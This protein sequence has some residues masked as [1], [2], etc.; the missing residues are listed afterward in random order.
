MRTLMVTV[1][2]VIAGLIA[3]LAAAWLTPDAQRWA[4]WPAVLINLGTTLLVLIPVYTIERQLNRRIEAIRGEFDAAIRDLL[5]ELKGNL[6]S[7]TRDT[8][9][10]EV[11][12]AEARFKKDQNVGA[13]LDLLKIG[14]KYSLYA[15]DAIVISL[16]AAR[17][18]WLGI[19]AASDDELVEVYEKKGKPLPASGSVLKLRI[20]S[21]D[22]IP[23]AKTNCFFTTGYDLPSIVTT[24]VTQPLLAVS[25]NLDAAKV[26]SD[27]SEGLGLG[28]L[29]ALKQRVRMIPDPRQRLKEPGLLISMV[30]LGWMIT[31]LGIVRN[32]DGLRLHARS[33]WLGRLWW[34]SWGLDPEESRGYTKALRLARAMGRVHPR[35]EGWWRSRLCTLGNLGFVLAWAVAS[36]L[37]TWLCSLFLH[38]SSPADWALA[39]SCVSAIAAAS[40]ILAF[41]KIGEWEGDG[42]VVPGSLLCASIMSWVIIWTAA[43]LESLMGLNSWQPFWLC[44]ALVVT[45]LS[46]LGAASFI[47]DGIRWW[48]RTRIRPPFYVA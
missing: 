20:G 7:A 17:P 36:A 47:R 34:G 28:L 41:V 45:V 18:T 2:L 19:A 42:W 8:M 4:T 39:A 31:D 38:F 22:A 27:V 25:G 46:L 11:N 40:L 48:R 30:S 43:P 23:Q 35:L 32:R 24:T 16:P 14:S 3:L 6:E 1:G 21:T 44:L 15:G 12:E 26:P 9:L 10:N 13:V 37:V 5:V 29:Q 33:L